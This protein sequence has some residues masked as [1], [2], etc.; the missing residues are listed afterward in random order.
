MLSLM[1]HSRACACMLQVLGLCDM[2]MCTCLCVSQVLGLGA[3]LIAWMARLTRYHGIQPY[4]LHPPVVEGAVGCM[5][6]A[7][8]ALAGQQMMAGGV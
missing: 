2:C 4:Q 5:R 6:D 8:T 1:K 7:A 3:E